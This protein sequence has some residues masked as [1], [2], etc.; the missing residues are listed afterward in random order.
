MRSEKS[1][2]KRHCDNKHKDPKGK[3]VRNE[4]FLKYGQVPSESDCRSFA[5]FLEALER[6]AVQRS[7]IQPPEVPDDQPFG[8]QKTEIKS[9]ML[10]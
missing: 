2:L 5:E 6:D 3:K 9:V 7:K 10:K 1:I 8:K 4:G